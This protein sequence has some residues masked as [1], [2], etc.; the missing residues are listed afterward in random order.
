MNIHYV[1]PFIGSL[2]GS[3]VG[4]LMANKFIGWIKPLVINA[5]ALSVQKSKKSN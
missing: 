4:I 5:A 3:L 1:A 2:I